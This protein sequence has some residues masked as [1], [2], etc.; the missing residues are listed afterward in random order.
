[1][2]IDMLSKAVQISIFVFVVSSMLAMGSALTVAQ[3]IDPLRNVRLIV[4]TLLANFVLMPLIAVALVK[5]LR[6]D[7][8][9]GDGLLL[10]G[11]R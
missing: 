4:L 9:L 6:I 5:V 11:W 10:L 1:M 8:Q 2:L 3:I 7:A